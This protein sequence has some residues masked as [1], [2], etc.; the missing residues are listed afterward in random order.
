MFRAI[1]LERQ[2]RDNW[3]A[4]ARWERERETAK[5]NLGNQERSL[6]ADG[7]M[8]D[9]RNQWAPLFMFP[10]HSESSKWELYP[11][12]STNLQGCYN[13][14]P[15]THPPPTAG[16][17]S[18]WNRRVLHWTRSPSS[19]R[20]IQHVWQGAA[21][22]THWAA[23]ICGAPMIEESADLGKRCGT[24]MQSCSLWN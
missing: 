9:W 8:Q 19:W 18:S 24:C 15:A 10:L 4:S 11:Y 17:C 22:C 14:S 12:S 6:E 23:C 13:M 20:L 3:T 21:T 16:A 2:L 7:T 5:R 1:F